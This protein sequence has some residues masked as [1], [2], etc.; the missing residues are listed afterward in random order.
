MYVIDYREASVVEE[1]LR[2]SYYIYDISIECQ[3]TR[4]SIAIAIS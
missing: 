3:L 2:K 4:L 1:T